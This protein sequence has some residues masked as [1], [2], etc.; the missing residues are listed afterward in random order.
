MSTSH[1]VGL[2]STAP[3]CWLCTHNKTIPHAYTGNVGPQH[4]APNRC[5]KANRND[6]VLLP[7]KLFVFPQDQ[8]SVNVCSRP[9]DT[10]CSPQDKLPARTNTRSPAQGPA[11]ASRG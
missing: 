4:R 6:S 1:R 2:L 10:T 5:P 9:P 8:S 11:A 7:I 3:L